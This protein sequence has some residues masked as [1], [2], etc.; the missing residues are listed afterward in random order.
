MKFRVLMPSIE[1]WIRV[2]RLEWHML[3]VATGLCCL[4]AAWAGST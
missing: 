1:I 2:E 3:L 4:R